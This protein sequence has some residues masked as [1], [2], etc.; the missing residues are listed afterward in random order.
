MEWDLSFGADVG[1]ARVIGC[2]AGSNAAGRAGRGI[3][4]SGGCSRTLRRISTLAV[5][6]D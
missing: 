4:G 6:G 2:R 1:A 5:F 3:E